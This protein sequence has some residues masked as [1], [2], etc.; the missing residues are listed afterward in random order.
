MGSSTETIYLKDNP[1]GQ[2]K[3]NSALTLHPPE[4][5]ISIP[6]EIPIPQYVRGKCMYYWN[7]Q[8]SVLETWRRKITAHA[9]QSNNF[10]S[11]ISLIASFPRFS[12]FPGLSSLLLQ[13]PHSVTQ[14]KNSINIL[15]NCAFSLS[16]Y[17]S[18]SEITAP[19][20]GP[21]PGNGGTWPLS[22]THPKQSKENK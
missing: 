10:P 13:V 16:W 2:A 6:R 18:L 11:N 14:S 21:C 17:P 15:S 22:A 1:A 7:L 20:V 12:T 4:S 9:T 5:K 3:E 19:G 8:Q